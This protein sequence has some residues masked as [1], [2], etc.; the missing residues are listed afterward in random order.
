MSNT[1]YSGNSS[2]FSEAVSGAKDQPSPIYHVFLSH[3]S[4]DKPAVTELARKLSSEGI[5]LFL[6]E[7]NLVPGAPWQ[8][9]LEEALEASRACAVFIG[10]SGMGPWQHEEMR[11]AIERRVQRGGGDFRVIPVL[12]PGAERG[13]R[14]KLPTFLTASTWVVF[15]RSIEEADALRRLICGI[16]AIAPGP[17]PNQARFSDRCPYR[18]LR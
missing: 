15:E 17:G 5:E 9:A 6:D 12:L 2:G 13:P 16:R 18:G 8:A 7:W 4:S 10:P 11:A 1:E 3:R 14:S